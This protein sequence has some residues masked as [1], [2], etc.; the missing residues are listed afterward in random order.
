MR[1]RVE[2]ERRVFGGGIVGRIVRKF[3]EVEATVEYRDGET[4]RLTRG[5][6]GSK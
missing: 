2:R 1:T 4:Q 5:T 3:K 6:G